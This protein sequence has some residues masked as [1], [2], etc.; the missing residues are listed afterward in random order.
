MADPIPEEIQGL[1]NGI[2]KTLQGAIDA[3]VGPGK[4]CFSLFIFDVDATEGRT[5]YISSATR[6]SVASTLK[7]FLAKYEED[8]GT[9]D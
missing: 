5:S 4:L 6:E 3:Q 1:M 8:Y 9:I 2:G 7:E